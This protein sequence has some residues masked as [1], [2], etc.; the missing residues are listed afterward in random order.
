MAFCSGCTVAAAG[1]GTRPATEHVS[2]IHTDVK[3]SSNA[4]GAGE[5]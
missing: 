3:C 5:G 4:L 2:R 1:K